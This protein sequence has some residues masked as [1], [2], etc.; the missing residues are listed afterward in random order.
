M[1]Q[2]VSFSDL[3][4]YSDHVL[5]DGSF[6]PLHAGHLAYLAAAKALNRGPLLCA[7]ASDDQIREKGREPLLPQDTRVAVMQ[8]LGLTVY[9]KDRPTEHVIE[10]MAPRAYVKGSD[11]CDRLPPEQVSACGRTGT[12][13]IW[14]SDV[15]RR[16]SSTRRLRA[17]ARSEDAKHLEAFERLVQSQKPAEKPWQPV[18]DYSFDDLLADFRRSIGSPVVTMVVAGGMLDF[19][20]ERGRQLIR[21]LSE[22]VGAATEDHDFAA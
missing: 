14:A 15:E 12:P 22:R 11:W 2:R 16:D 20:S 10:K 9:A 21:C 13:I 6:D 3:P 18:T 7:V 8:A 19:S 1:S 17:W 5:V 4:A